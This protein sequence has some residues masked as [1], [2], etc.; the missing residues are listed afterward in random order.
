[1]RREQRMRQ[2]MKNTFPLGQRAVAE[3]GLLRQIEPGQ[4]V[5]TK[6]RLVVGEQGS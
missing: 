2:D 6:I 1:M 5:E 3:K 4:V